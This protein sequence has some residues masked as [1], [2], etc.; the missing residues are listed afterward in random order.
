[1]R[2]EGRERGRRAGE[3]AAT[4]QGIGGGLYAHRIVWG[5]VCM[6]PR[7]HACMC[8]CVW[9]LARRAVATTSVARVSMHDVGSQSNR[10]V[11]LLSLPNPVASYPG[12]LLVPGRVFGTRWG[13][14]PGGALSTVATYRWRLRLGVNSTSATVWRTRSS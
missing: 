3:R 9:P 14:F 11:P 4:G 5:V 6:R 13:F 1:M 2:G 8:M 10:P 12:R 7:A